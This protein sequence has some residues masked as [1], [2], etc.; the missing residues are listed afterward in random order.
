MNERTDAQLMLYGDVERFD[1]LQ[2]RQ[3]AMLQNLNFYQK[4]YF[5]EKFIS[6]NMHMQSDLTKNI[7]FNQRN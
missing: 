2:F 1:A 7:L 5:F 4:R 6:I 3:N